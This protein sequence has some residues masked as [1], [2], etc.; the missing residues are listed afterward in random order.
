[1][2]NPDLRASDEDRDRVAADIREHYAQGRLDRA[3]LDE[4]LKETFSVK[5]VGELDALVADLPELS[6]AV[7]QAHTEVALQR[8]K[9]SR[10]LVQETGG[11]LIPFI[12]CTV[13]WVLGGANGSFWP[14]WALIFPIVVLARDGW[15]L[16]GPAPE[17]D[18]AAESPEERRNGRR[19]KP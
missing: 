7:T 15:R 10:E 4:R 14:V 18:R 6:L 19:P 13:V 2:A 11:A 5:T 8:A 9:L 16:F 1:V 17:L 12:L 3:E